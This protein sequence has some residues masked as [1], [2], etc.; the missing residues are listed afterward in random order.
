MH[1]VYENGVERQIVLRLLYFIFFFFYLGYIGVGLDGGKN[2]CE[3]FMII[4]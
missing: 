2:L 1:F 3:L 4:L